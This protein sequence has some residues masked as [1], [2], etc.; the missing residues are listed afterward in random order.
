M[1]E[2]LSC[3]AATARPRSVPASLIAPDTS[4]PANTFKLFATYKLASVGNGLTLGGGVRWQSEIYSERSVFPGGGAAPIPVRFTQ[5]AYAVVDL[6]ARYQ[7]TRNLGASVNLNNAFDK[8]YH[9]ST[10]N[11]YYGT[12]R[13]VR[14]A[15]DVKF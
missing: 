9:M 5:E 13:E 15:L 10:W 14:A 7:I 3:T 11:S 1:Y 8:S 2:S 12:P 4:I 6:M